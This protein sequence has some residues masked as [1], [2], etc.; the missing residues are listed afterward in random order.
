MVP[1][2]RVVKVGPR[3]SPAHDF[4]TIGGN[5]VG[6]HSVDGLENVLADQ[7]G[8][9]VKENG[10]RLRA[11]SPARLDTRP[12]NWVSPRGVML[13]PGPEGACSRCTCQSDAFSCQRT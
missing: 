2:P 7:P 4:S 8:Q 9:P 5:L 10:Q 11:W 6:R 3:P 13:H 12:R 1:H